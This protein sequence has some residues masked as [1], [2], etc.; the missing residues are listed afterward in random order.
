MSGR[1]LCDG[2]IVKLT[3]SIPTLEPLGVT[4]DSLGVI[5]NCD[6]MYYVVWQKSNGH[7]GEIRIAMKPEE[8]TPTGS[9]V[10]KEVLSNLKKQDHQLYLAEGL[11]NPRDYPPPS[12]YA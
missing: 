5:I 6:Q 10:S 11:E 12:R 9:Y 4:E 8:I 1:D 2:A 3:T 7:Q